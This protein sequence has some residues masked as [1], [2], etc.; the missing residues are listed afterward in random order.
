M[1][2]SKRFSIESF[3]SRKYRPLIF[4]EGKKFRKS[5]FMRKCRINKTTKRSFLLKWEKFR[6]FA[7]MM[8]FVC[9]SK[10]TC[11]LNKVV[12]N[13]EH[14]FLIRVKINDK[15]LNPINSEHTKKSIKLLFVVPIN[16]SQIYWSFIQDHRMKFFHEFLLI[17]ILYNRVRES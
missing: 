16:S 11:F 12:I 17:L 13:N 15:R 8:P 10:I 6:I 4:S 5:C 9:K 1:T 2:F 3:D 7:E 14:L